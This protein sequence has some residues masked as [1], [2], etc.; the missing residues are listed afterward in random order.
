MPNRKYDTPLDGFF[1]TGFD[2]FDFWRSRDNTDTDIVAFGFTS[3]KPIFGDGKVICAIDL[4]ERPE[5]FFGRQ[6][7]LWRV[8]A[9]L[10]KL[11]EW[12]LRMPPENG[13]GIWG[14]VGAK[15]V[16]KVRVK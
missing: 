3:H 7:I 2:T 1:N 16:E 14:V 10:G 11:N 4:F 13:C 8:G 5:P 6:E 12:P 9:P 15:K